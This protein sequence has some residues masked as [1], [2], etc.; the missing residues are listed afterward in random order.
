MTSRID[1]IRTAI[2]ASIAGV[3]VFFR[4]WRLDASCLWFDEMFSVQAATMG[5]GEML[6]FLS[7]DLVHPP[8]F[9]V[10]LKFWVLIG[11]DSVFW[12]RALPA[13]CAC[14]AIVPFLLVCRELRL[15]FSAAALGLFFFAINGSL[16]KY[17]QEVRMYT[18]LSCLSLFS[19]W[20]FLRWLLRDR[21]I[22]PLVA[23]NLIAVYTHYFAWTVIGCELLAVL[24]LDRR[25]LRGA[26]AMA[27]GLAAAFLPWAANVVLTARSGDLGENIDWIQRPGP[28]VIFDFVFDLVEPFYY[29]QSSAEPAS[30]YKIAL[31][32]L[33]IAAAALAAYSVRLV[34][35][36]D[37]RRAAGILL[38][39]CIP[40][41]AVVFVASWVLPYSVWG[42]RHLIVVFAPICIL[43]ANA[44][45]KVDVNGLRT[46]AVTGIMVLST[47]AGY[48]ALVRP[49]PNYVWCGWE[50]LM[51]DVREPAGQPIDVYTS[52]NLAAYHMFF[53]DRKEGKFR[54]HIV[55][56]PEGEFVDREY[57]PPRGVDGIRWA[58]VEDIVEPHILLI[59]RLERPSLT[60]WLKRRLIANGYTECISKAA[61]YGPSTLVRV[62]LT[63]EPG[64]CKYGP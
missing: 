42:T 64:E 45:T 62:E 20:F 14:V 21:S 25:K 7:L 38:L 2:I 9:Y 30:L 1:P 29:Q 52:E 37:E 34:T 4:F 33:L 56:A 50:P 22:W 28:R 63:K 44:V 54:T 58:R 8:L 26:A 59:Y 35:D 18:L 46:A 61:D 16:I 55:K 13:A 27:G 10:V 3:Y 17:A 15:K 57:F 60:D 36:H 19:V 11:G 53:S 40:T 12:V 39:F 47:Y 31:P 24:I 23:V 41:L 48:A 5:W 43:A 6:R 51:S 32:L 49:V